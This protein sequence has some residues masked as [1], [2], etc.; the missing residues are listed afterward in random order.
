MFWMQD[1]WSE[2]LSAT[3]AIS[4]EKILKMVDILVRFIYRGC[5]QILVQSRAFNE[6]VKRQGGDSLKALLS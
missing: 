5:D 4:S 3:G 6:S 1:L 2:S